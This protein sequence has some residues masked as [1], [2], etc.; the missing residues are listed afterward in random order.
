MVSARRSSRRASTAAARSGV[1]PPATVFA[2]RTGPPALASRD[3][4]RFQH[5]TDLVPVRTDDRRRRLCTAHSRAW[6]CQ[7]RARGGHVSVPR[8]RKPSSAQS[9]ISW[10]CLLRFAST[11]HTH[12]HLTTK[13]TVAS[14]SIHRSQASPA[15]A[16]VPCTSVAYNVL[17]A[18]GPMLYS[19]YPFSSSRL[20]LLQQCSVLCHRA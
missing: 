3:W 17:V 10:D 1:S 16:P 2:N 6:I 8:Q 13:A 11:P 9:S 20:T 7:R 14:Q 4:F 5:A 15:E 19:L 18:A 12:P